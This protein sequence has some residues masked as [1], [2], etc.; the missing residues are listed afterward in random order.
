[1]RRLDGQTR[2]SARRG[3]T[4]RA[5]GTT[6]YGRKLVAAPVA[7]RTA[8]VCLCPHSAG[9]A[10]APIPGRGNV[11]ACFHDHVLDV[12]TFSS[13]RGQLPAMSNSDLDLVLLGCQTSEMAHYAMHS[14][15]PLPMQF[16]LPSS[17]R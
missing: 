17:R 1:M 11:G 10:G 8:T 14:Y 13:R 15:C 4:R 5:R 16:P 3:W 9:G 2:R 7:R 6:G 12:A